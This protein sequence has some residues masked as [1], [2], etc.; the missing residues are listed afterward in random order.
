[1]L[2]QF[3]YNWFLLYYFFLGIVVL[4]QGIVWIRNPMPFVWYLVTAAD[5]ERCPRYFIKLI[6]YIFVFSLI[7]LFFAFFPFSVFELIFSLFSLFMVYVIGSLLLKWPDL[8]NAITEYQESLKK[9]IFRLGMILLT[10]SVIIFALC[11]RI[12]L[13]SEL[14]SG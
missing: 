5:Q 3:S 9:P 10:F 12:I 1:M 2:E 7:S 4:I 6:R 14:N 8:R 11:Y 13:T